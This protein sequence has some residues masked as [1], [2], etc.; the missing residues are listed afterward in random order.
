MG[1]VL[2]ERDIRSSVFFSKEP[3]GSC[4]APGA[5]Y[6]HGRG[7]QRLRTAAP[8]DLCQSRRYRWHPALDQSPHREALNR[9][10]LH[11]RMMEDMKHAQKL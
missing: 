8:C 10:D 2:C 6:Q 3:H 4:P 11:A 5:D 9:V 1:N 7:E